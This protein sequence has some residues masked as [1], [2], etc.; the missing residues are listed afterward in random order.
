MTL[1]VPGR[2][3]PLDR[4]LTLLEQAKTPTM[5]APD[6][7][8][9]VG[10]DLTSLLLRLGVLVEVEPVD[11]HPC[12]GAFG[13]GCPRRVV[14]NRGCA[15]HPFVAVCG[16]DDTGCVEVL[17]R[18]RDRVTLELSL[19]G[20]VRVLHRVLGVQGLVER[21]TSFPDVCKIGDVD[22][23]LIFLALSPVMP[24]FDAWL[25][26]R[27]DATVLLPAARGVPTALRDRF[28]VGQR[29]QLVVLREILHLEGD[30][31]A[32]ALPGVS[33]ALTPV[34]ART[35]TRSGKS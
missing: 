22:G 29:V 9:R 21:T 32:G 12:G 15:E 28:A 3:T 16:R 5:H 35:T 26:A 33:A 11:W 31:L 20:L 2:G 27:G 10:V 23:R 8:A 18:A 17:L 30:V 13:D 25:A 7:H 19:D 34:P 6:W 1:L 24:G 14:P 4:L